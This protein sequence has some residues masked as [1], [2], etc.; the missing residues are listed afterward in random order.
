M[1]EYSFIVYY[2]A[3]SSNYP[4]FNKDLI[5]PIIY[6]LK[7]SQHTEPYSKKSPN[8]IYKLY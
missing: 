7:Y 8:V 6:N 5:Q 2:K 1:K 3:F 4:I